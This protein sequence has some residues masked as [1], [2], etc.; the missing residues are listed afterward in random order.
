MSG[1]A[2]ITE[3]ARGVTPPKSAIAPP[4][5]NATAGLHMPYK[6]MDNAIINAMHEGRWANWMWDVE[7]YNAST[8][9]ITFGRGGFQDSR[10]SLTGAAGDWFIEN[11]ARQS[12]LVNSN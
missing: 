3:I 4:G 7:T 8:N 5:S 6:T 11:G 1:G 2:H 10:G 9:A 12:P